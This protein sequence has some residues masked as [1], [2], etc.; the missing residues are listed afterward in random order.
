MKYLKFSLTIKLISN[1]S[2]FLF[3]TCN[4]WFIK[5]LRKEIIKI[6]PKINNYCENHL[7]Y[8]SFWQDSLIL[9]PQAF[10]ELTQPPSFKR[11]RQ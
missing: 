3:L 4:L 1:S 11:A 8:D 7:V 2:I 9:F 6:D 5:S 10:F